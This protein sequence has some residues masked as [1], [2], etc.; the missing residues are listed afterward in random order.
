MAPST[1]WLAAVAAVTGVL[2]AVSLVVGLAWDREADL[3]AGTPEGT[4]QAYLRAVADRDASAA[5]GFYAP[6]LRDRCELSYVRDS[7]R[8]RTN[9]FRATLAHVNQQGEATEVT[10]TITE[11]YGSGPLGR[12]E[13]T[14]DQ[15]FLLEQV[16]SEWRFVEPPWPTWCPV[17]ARPGVVVP[18]ATAEAAQ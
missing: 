2:V 16:D 7:L 17:E 1:R 12:N 4:V 9:D 8:W 11:V 14:F 13:S 15:V 3:D 18:D 6:A 10:I 5:L